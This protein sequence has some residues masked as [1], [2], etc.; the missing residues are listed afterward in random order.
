MPKSDRSRG[1]KRRPDFDEAKYVG[2]GQ[3]SRAS[4]TSLYSGFM[5]SQPCSSD[6]IRSRRHRSNS[7]CNSSRL[8]PYPSN[9]SFTRPNQ[10]AQLRMSSTA[11]D[12]SSAMNRAMTALS[13]PEI[14]RGRARF[15]DSRTSSSM[16]PANDSGHRSRATARPADMTSPPLSQQTPSKSKTKTSSGA[17]LATPRPDRREELCKEAARPGVGRAH[18]QGEGVQT[19]VMSS[20]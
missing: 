16:T 15:N 5:A 12:P 11:P 4:R 3:S 6:S 10:S 8:L 13:N 1:I 9:S 17:H 19:L 14:N 18:Q 20:L 2:L 7:P